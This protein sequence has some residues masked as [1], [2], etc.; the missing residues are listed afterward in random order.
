MEINTDKRLNEK[1]EDKHKSRVSSFVKKYCNLQNLFKVSFSLLL[2]AIICAAI[3][4]L[5]S[6]FGIVNLV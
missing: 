5:I 2:I 3:C 4:F 6:N 1:T